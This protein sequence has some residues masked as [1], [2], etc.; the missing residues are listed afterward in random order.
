MLPSDLGGEITEDGVVADWVEADDAEG[1]G[2]H[3]ALDTII[4]VGNSLE[5]RKTGEGVLA[6]GSLLMALRGDEKGKEEGGVSSVCVFEKI[7]NCAYYPKISN[8]K[9][10]Q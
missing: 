9:T 6:T 1:G 10:R 7:K 8:L 5:S 4:W 2:D 3:L